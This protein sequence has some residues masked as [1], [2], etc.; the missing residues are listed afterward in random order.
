VPLRP[1]IHLLASS[2]CVEERLR[3]VGCL[4][5]HLSHRILGYRDRARASMFASDN[6]TVEVDALAGF[7]ALGFDAV[8][9]CEV[10]P[11]V[12]RV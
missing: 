5:L 10:C 3:G 7:A 11:G 6:D 12:V 8:S 2:C 1:A 9:K 4:F